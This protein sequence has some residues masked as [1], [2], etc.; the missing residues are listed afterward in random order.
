MLLLGDDAKVDFNNEIIWNKRKSKG[1]RE[2]GALT[3][4]EKKKI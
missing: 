1:D 2:G 4:G 3:S